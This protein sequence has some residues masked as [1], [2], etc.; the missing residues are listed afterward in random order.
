VRLRDVSGTVVSEDPRTHRYRKLQRLKTGRPARVLDLFAGCG[1][2][3]LGFRASGC[4]IVGAVENDPIAARTMA[5]N[6][7]GQEMDMRCAARDIRRT[8]AKDLAEVLSPGE[9]PCELVDLIV[10]GPPCQAFARVGRAKLREVARDPQAYQSD[11]RANLYLHYL[12]YVKTLQP[13]AILI[14]NV[15]DVLNYGGSNIP[16]LICRDLDQAG[17]RCKYT[18]LNAAHY[19]VPQLRERMFL[20]AYAEE[21][22]VEPEFPAPTH[23]WEIPKGYL[24]AR[25]R[26]LAFKRRLEETGYLVYP[27]VPQNDCWLPV[28]ITAEEAIGDLPEIKQHLEGKLPRSARYRKQL[29]SYRRDVAPSCY[30]LLMKNWPG[31]KSGEVVQ[32]HVIRWLPRDYPIFA[33]MQPGDEYPQA[34]QKAEQL[35]RE[36]I[37]K[38]C[39]EAKTLIEGSLEYEDLRRKIVPPYDGGKFPN[40]WRKMEPDAPARTLMAHLGKDTYTH[41]HYDSTQARTI[42]VREAAR[43]QSFPDGFRFCGG[44]NAAFRQIGNAVPPL[45]ANVLACEILKALGVPDPPEPLV[46]RLMAGSEEVDRG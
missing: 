28:A 31:F 34:L 38:L 35:F 32:D 16:E 24:G 37:Q 17:Y 8:K 45:L 40:K 12:E 11:V 29:L 6:F 3:S 27:P 10:G 33:R 1:G 43:L 30:A 44:M 36:K 46:N 18:I 42:S 4:E 14:E 23:R 39:S 26:R 15:P 41:I 20:L 19:G 5:V 7:Y 22:G 9:D 13:L 25:Y 2:I 21:L